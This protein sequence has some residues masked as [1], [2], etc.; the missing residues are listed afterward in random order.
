MSN[1]LRVGIVGCGAIASNHVSAY[2]A[3]EGAVV[4]GC[5]DIDIT[6]AEAFAD[7][8]GINA[9]TDSV[10]KLLELNLDIISVCTPHPTHESVVVA[11]AAR[12]VHVLCEKPIAIDSES[13]QRMIDACANADVKLGVLF[14][15]RFWPAARRIRAAI[16]DGTIGRPVLG[17]CSVLLHREHEYYS[18]DAWRGMWATDGGGVL[19]TQAI[20]YIDLL[21]WFMGP[22]VE[23]TGRTGPISTATAL[24]SRIPP[25]PRWLLPPGHWPPSKL[26]R[27]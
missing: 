27:R 21:Q 8:Q 12:G 20:H 22:V 4:V 19:M 1:D 7:V 3:A 14:Q 5:C 24:K 9:A 23:V 11:A 16:E 17:H 15:R 10:E 13:A 6:R 26:R 25:S 2:A 18:A